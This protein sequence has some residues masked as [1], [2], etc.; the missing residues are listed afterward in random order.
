MSPVVLAIVPD[1]FFF[2]KI[3]ATARATGIELHSG[4]VTDALE[5]C[6]RLRPAMVLLD[7]HAS[8]D[9]PALIRAL[10]TDERTRA[11]PVTGFFS[12]VQI[13]VRN[14]AVEAGIDTAW[15][16]SAFVTRLSGLFTECATRTTPPS[17]AS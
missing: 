1:L 13:D 11:I 4:P 15:P 6:A 12:H 2:A 14:A 7:L 10:K 17:E 5:L 3:E 9:L 8:G 16:R